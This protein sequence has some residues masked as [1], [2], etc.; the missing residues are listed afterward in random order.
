MAEHEVRT[1]LAALPLFC[2]LLLIVGVC[3]G[4]PMESAD[5]VMYVWPCPTELHFHVLV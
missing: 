5:Q 3:L 2:L 4:V 1:F